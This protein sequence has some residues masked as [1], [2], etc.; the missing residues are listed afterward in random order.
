MAIKEMKN[1]AFVL[2]GP[3][4]VSF[5]DRPVP[6]ITDP[7]S[8][9]IRVNYTGICGSDVHYWCNGRLGPFVLERLMV[10]GHESAGT[11]IQVGDKVQ[12]LQKGDR[13]AMEPGIPC[14]RCDRC[15]EGNY[16]LCLE[17][18]FAATPPYDG[19][20]ATY[21]IL[22]ED[23][24]YKL[25]ENVSLEEGSLLEP[26]SVAVHI[27]R[28]SN[29][30]H[31]DT[32]VVFGAGPI[33][34]LCCAVARA[35]G[36]RKIIAV[37]IQK[38]RLE[39]ASKFAAT[40]TYKPSSASPEE[41]AQILKK[42]HNLGTGAD[43]VLDASG[44]EASVQTAIYLL[45]RGG[46][47]VQGGLGKNQVHF[48]IAEA[49]TNELTIRGSFRYS[50]GDYQTALDLVAAGKVDVKA[51]ITSKVAFEEAESAFQAVK[52]GKAIKVLIAGPQ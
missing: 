49:C 38:Q 3:L 18:A 15:K 34:L 8:I 46:S 1:K 30:K 31:G 28:Q 44:A 48:P 27:L 29:L 42:E 11:V 35:Y 13:V 20:L 21:Y 45:R 6:K 2:R 23:L 12:S 5:E 47:Y 32:I 4:D 36:A 19:T 41:N 16:N 50:A 24:C 51:L 26:L 52:A 22:P 33:G 10:L 40:A 43:V 25:P 9:L 39:F 7:Y 14:R 17:M 37:D